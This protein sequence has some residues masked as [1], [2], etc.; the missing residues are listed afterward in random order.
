M[1]VDIATA[2]APTTDTDMTATADPEGPT[3][4]A[5]L[6]REART[7]GATA[8]DEPQSK[9]L[10][11]HYGLRVPA[12]RVA[13]DADAAVQALRALA[14]PVAM[15]LIAPGAHKSDIGGVVLGLSDEAAVRAA[16]DSILASARTHGVDAGGVLVER[17]ADPGHE[18]VI[19]GFNDARFGPVIM[20]G[21]GGV[22]VEVFDD[23][24][25]R[26]CPIDAHDARGMIDSL[27]SAPLL[28]GARGGTRIDEAS[29]VDALLAI[30][31]ETGL[32]VRHAD[33]V[34]EIDF[35][36]VIVGGSGATV[37]DARVILRAEAN[38]APGTA[39][40]AA[41]PAQADARD[42]VARFGALL[43]PR[44]VAVAGASSTGVTMANDFIRQS[45]ALGF[46][47][48]LIPIHP[49]AE[50][51]EG[52]PAVRS[53]AQIDVPVD[54][55]YIAVAAP[56]VPEM[57]RAAA[58]KV[59][60]A[61][62][63]SSG[64][65]EIASGRA[66]E[67]ELATAARQS[68]VRTLGPNCLGLY[69]PRAG[70]SFIGDCPTDAGPVGIISQSGGLGVDIILRGKTRGIRFSGVVTLGNSV[71]IGPADLL[72]YYLAD[73]RTRVIGVYL[74]D[75]KDGRRFF[76]T[77]RRARADKPV[78]LLLGGQTAQG[79]RAAASHT[80]SLATPLA[81]WRGL[82]EQTGAV[83]AQTLEQFLDQ[84][85][86]FQTL[87]PNAARATRR[88]VLFGNGG[89]TSVLAADAFAREGLDVSPM[90]EP[91]ISGLDALALPSG[92]SVV[93]PIDTP[94]PTLRQQ[95]G[96]VAERILDI[97]CSLA[98][99]DAVVTHLNLP[100]F[101]SSANQQAD[102]LANLTQA[103][104]RVQQRHPGRAHFALVLRSDGS[105]ACDLRKR[106]FRREAMAQNIPVYDELSNAAAGLGALARYERFLAMRAGRAG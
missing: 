50:T 31:G 102:Y 105:E 86:T 90:P 104:L 27:R 26:V 100:V 34:A 103:V 98:E 18:I 78:V 45:L 23:V 24:A 1:I 61:Q 46:G 73:E 77:L 62:V 25:F 16:F 42:V 83:L 76:D 20:L 96:R 22:F 67:A 11:V 99:P 87:S 17:M 3:R 63:I 92:T 21:L 35:N 30:G 38:A 15:K 36:P 14:G 89:G 44:T 60:Y 13:T 79:G 55:L 65:G 101:V 97:V 9:A 75:V 39:P 57:I 94:G 84:L 64:F 66:L 29:L 93:N 49:S 5:T 53:L 40:D 59:K 54:Y 10:A 81:L 95:E 82:A 80:G 32:L 51:I 41:S 19:G 91:A 106:A 2:A 12:S 4:V 58:G 48:R 37:C 71:D 88:C 28:R 33:A 74:E 6:L 85:T 68:G 8:L 43:E 72:E 69:S 56:K 7:R 52:L 47:G 70:L